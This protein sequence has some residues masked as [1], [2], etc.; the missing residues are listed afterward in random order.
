MSGNEGDQDLKLVSS[1]N[2]EL[3]CSMYHRYLPPP[4]AHSY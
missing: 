4:S 3:S 1:D 2:E